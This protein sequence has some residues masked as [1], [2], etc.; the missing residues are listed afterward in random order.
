M[1]VHGVRVG[2]VFEYIY[3]NTHADSSRLKSVLL[4][5]SVVCI[6]HTYS[7]VC[8]RHGRFCVGFFVGS[9]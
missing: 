3:L 1:R 2:A 7:I 9:I 6:V 5:F 4:V 8:I